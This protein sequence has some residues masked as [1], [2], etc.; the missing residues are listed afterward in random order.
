[1]P[2]A[3][4]EPLAILEESIDSL[5]AEMRA[6]SDEAAEMTP[7]PSVQAISGAV[8]N[9]IDHL[10]RAKQALRALLQIVEG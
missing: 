1:M 4:A 2:A 6:A 5:R 8:G 3:L 10:D 9:A 7:T